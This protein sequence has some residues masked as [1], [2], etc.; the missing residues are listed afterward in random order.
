MSN[1][2]LLAEV[3]LS[4]IKNFTIKKYFYYFFKTLFGEGFGDNVI[5]N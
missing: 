1:P 5:K 3:K 2:K 4:M